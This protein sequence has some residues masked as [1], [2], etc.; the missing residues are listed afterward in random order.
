M[1]TIKKG[2]FRKITDETN[3]SEYPHNSFSFSFESV[4]NVYIIGNIE[5]KF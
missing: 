4:H 2:K 3:D 1:K 5:Y